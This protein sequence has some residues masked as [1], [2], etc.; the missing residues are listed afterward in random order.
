[1]PD[2]QTLNAKDSALFVG[3]SQRHWSLLVSRGQTPAPLKVGKWPR[4]S[5]DE[6]R[7]WLAAGAPDQTAWEKLKANRELST[8]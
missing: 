5:I 6:L 7:E 8:P 3:Y 4:W 1:M 2:P